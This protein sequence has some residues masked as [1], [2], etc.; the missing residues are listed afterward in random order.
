MKDMANEPIIVKDDYL[1]ELKKEQIRKK[2]EDID[3]IESQRQTY[4]RSCFEK[5]N[6][7]KFDHDELIRNKMAIK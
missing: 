1:I 3:V 2:R 5:K 7:I 4:N 6:P